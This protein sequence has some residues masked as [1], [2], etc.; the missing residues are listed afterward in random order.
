M[1]FNWGEVKSLDGKLKSA[2]IKPIFFGRLDTVSFD[3]CM[4][5]SGCNF[6]P[7]HSHGE[8][9]WFPTIHKEAHKVS[10]WRHIVTLHGGQAQAH[11]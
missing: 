10:S 7:F 11:P 9:L 8:S 2:T 5:C 4:I 1:K 6:G 3:C